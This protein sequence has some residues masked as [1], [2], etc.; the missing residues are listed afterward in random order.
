MIGALRDVKEQ[1]CQNGDKDVLAIVSGAS[2]RGFP[3]M[4][5]LT[6]APGHLWGVF[7]IPIKKKKYG[8]RVRHNREVQFVM[9][10]RERRAYD[11]KTAALLSG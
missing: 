3:V 4:L 10:E 8:T 9:C 6:S 5:M 2:D 1:K 11:T 7:N